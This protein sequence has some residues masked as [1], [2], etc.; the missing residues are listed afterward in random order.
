MLNQFFPQIIYTGI[1]LVIL[2][3]L[4]AVAVRIVRK[5]ANKVQRVQMRT[6]LTKKL[7]NYFYWFLVLV[8]LFGIWGINFGELSIFFSSVFAILGVALFAQWSI[9]SNITAGIIMF[10]TF[11]YRIGDFIKIHEGDNSIYGYIEDIKS[12]QV[13]I[14]SLNDEIISYPNS[15]MLQKAVSILS[16]KQI[17]ELKNKLEN[18]PMEEAED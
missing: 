11:P 13:I 15:M 17:Q 3:T 10:F 12:F 14:R 7:I 2:T 6:V 5:H 8:F 4:R 16:E 18:P 1:T 9:I